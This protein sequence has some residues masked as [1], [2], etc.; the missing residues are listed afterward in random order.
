MKEYIRSL[1]KG[2]VSTLVFRYYM[3]KFSELLFILYCMSSFYLL[4]FDTSFIAQRRL[5]DNQF[6]AVAVCLSV[7]IVG[8]VL[9]LFSLW[10]VFRYKTG[11]CGVCEN[12]EN[13]RFSFNSAT[14]YLL[15]KMSVSILKTVK[16]VFYMLPF[17]S[18]SGLIYL[19]LTQGI[20]SI[21]LITALLC[22]VIL[23]INGIL[24][25]FYV[26]QKFML[27]EY[28]FAEYQGKPIIEIVRK[29][30][31]VSDGKLRKCALMK[32]KRLIYRLIGIIIPVFLIKENVLEFIF[33][34]EKIIPHNAKKRYA[35]KS[36]V[37]YFGNQ[38]AG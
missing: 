31:E 17:L 13:L 14:K 34:T 5:F 16:L 28:C 37:F 20:D 29:S 36:V 1:L 26:C 11:I 19:F 9:L 33:L 32:T 23:F 18:L 21:I 27:I 4:V 25:Y 6:V 7:V 12:V 8:F 38:K 3:A 2:N 35:E 22:D 30:A 10:Q 15:L 24:S